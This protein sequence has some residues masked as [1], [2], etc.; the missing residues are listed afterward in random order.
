LIGGA[1]HEGGGARRQET[2]HFLLG[3]PLVAHQKA[4][5]AA[6]SRAVGEFCINQLFTVAGDDDGRLSY[7]IKENLF[8]RRP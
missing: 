7:L 6:S 4:R 3:T 5:R 8:K 1:V 2:N